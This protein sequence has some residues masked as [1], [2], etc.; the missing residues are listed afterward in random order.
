MCRLD[1]FVKGVEEL[2]DIGDWLLGA[3]EEP[4]SSQAGTFVPKVRANEPPFLQKGGT[5]G[6]PTSSFS[7]DILSQPVLGASCSKL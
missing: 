2:L 4:A 5:G 3:D 1:A 6:L 7:W